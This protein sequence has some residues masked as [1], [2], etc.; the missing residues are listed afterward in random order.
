MNLHN[1]YCFLVC[2]FFGCC[3]FRSLFSFALV[4]LL[5]AL[6]VS[7]AQNR[8]VGTHLFTTRHLILWLYGW[9]LIIWFLDFSRCRHSEFSFLATSSNGKQN[10][11]KS[12]KKKNSNNV[13]ESIHYKP[14]AFYSR[15]PS[16]EYWFSF[17][18][19]SP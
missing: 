3:F 15:L 16:I 5:C 4:L 12:V 13:F 14:I 11:I 18:I 6:F 9:R 10:G 1:C 8:A 2:I 17:L 7:N 19:F